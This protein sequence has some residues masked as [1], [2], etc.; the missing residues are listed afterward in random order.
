MGLITFRPGITEVRSPVLPTGYYFTDQY[1]T[2][3]RWRLRSVYDRQEIR[4]LLRHLQN[5]GSI[6]RRRGLDRLDENLEEDDSATFWCV[7]DVKAWYQ[8]C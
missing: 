3:M 2:E 1:Q 5:E 6:K 4:E 7:D 8:I